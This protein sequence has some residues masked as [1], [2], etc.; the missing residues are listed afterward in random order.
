MQKQDAVGQACSRNQAAH[1]EG[2]KAQVAVLLL[3]A[4]QVKDAE[5]C[6]LTFRQLL[7]RLL[8]D[9]HTQALAV[10]QG[11]LPCYTTTE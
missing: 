6:V 11:E 8:Q 3:E 10:V 1:Q 2:C 7:Q 4:S 9:Q 5:H